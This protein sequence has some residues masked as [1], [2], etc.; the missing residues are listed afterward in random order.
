MMMKG[1]AY[2]ISISLSYFCLCDT[3]SSK[4][5]DPFFLTTAC[6]KYFGNI[7]SPL[8]LHTYITPHREL[9][10]LVQGNLKADRVFKL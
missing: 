2:Y 8:V 3:S 6:D 1:E 4:V 5:R 10:G 9:T 7:L